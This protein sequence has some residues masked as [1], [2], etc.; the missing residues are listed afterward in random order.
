MLKNTKFTIPDASAVTVA[1]FRSRLAQCDDAMYVEYIVNPES[2]LRCTVIFIDGMIASDLAHEHIL[3]PLTTG[4]ELKSLHDGRAVVDAIL[5]GGLYHGQRKLCE[6]LDD[7]MTELLFGSVLV[8][9]DDCALAVAF[10]AKGFEKRAIAEPTNENVLKGS[11]ESFVEIMRVNTSIVR[12][13]IKSEELKVRQL[14]LG[15]RTNTSVAVLYMD[16]IVNAETLNRVIKQLESVEIEGLTTAGQFETLL[17]GKRFTL[18]P[19]AIYTERPDKLAGC[20]LEGRIGLIIDG[21]SIAYITPIDL[22]SLMQAPED[23]SH[24]YVLASFFRI[25][26]YIC[27]IASLILPA[28]YVSV[29]TFHQEM[30]PTQLVVSIISSKRGAPFPTY[31]EVLLMLI[32]FEVL[33]EAGLRLPRAVGQTVSIVGALVVGQA[34]IQAN[35]LSPGVVIIIAAAGITGFVVPSQ[36]LSNANRL[37]R[38][39]LVLLATIGG[40]FTTMLG[41]IAILYSM[42]TLEIFGTPYLSPLVANDGEQMFADTITRRSWATKSER[43]SNLH[44]ADITRKPE[45]SDDAE[46]NDGDGG[47][48]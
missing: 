7:A 40:L 19:Q 35:I 48:Q 10:D 37:L 3:K 23:Y 9:F 41:L 5:R 34:A 13:H 4:A 22:H 36:D 8:V 17:Y 27:T 30:I 47:A 29:T 15:R 44:P 12:R 39:A 11:R 1:A 31:M 26:R 20:L 14:T 43:P 32:A 24:H 2:G 18:F 16:G 21:L 25:L 38:I 46:S 6:T 33:L 42:C 28:L 45:K